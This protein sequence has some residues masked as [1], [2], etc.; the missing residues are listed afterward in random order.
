MRVDIYS[1]GS[2]RNNP[3]GPGGYGVILSC[4]DPEGRIHR[5]ERSCG[6]ERTTNNRM[7][8]MGVI[9]GL[10]ALTYPCDVHVWTDSR[11]VVDTF[12]KH[13]ID[14]WMKNG[15]KRKTGEVK[16]RDLWERLLK[17]KKM[18]SVTFH[19]VKGHNGHPENERCDELAVQAALGSHLK[20]DPGM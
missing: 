8:L 3:E 12:E 19:W 17:A 5:S 6:Y 10:E 7:E 11:Y 4:T 1:D 2:A 16:N 13:W 18:H 14:S 15:W 9:T 20:T